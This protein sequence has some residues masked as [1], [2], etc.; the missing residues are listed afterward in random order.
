MHMS[1]LLVAVEPPAIW[2]LPA[3]DGDT[4]A[5][6]VAALIE[7]SRK[8][9]DVSA[10]AATCS[11][12]ARALEADLRARKEQTLVALTRRLG[13]SVEMMADAQIL[14]STGTGITDSELLLLCCM[15]FNETAY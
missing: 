12:M 7:S 14:H 9:S 11:E 6:V 10:M 3:L 4:F 2:G 8:S 1:D 13:W 15:L 5:S